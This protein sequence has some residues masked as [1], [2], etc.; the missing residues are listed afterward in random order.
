MTFRYDNRSKVISRL[1]LFGDDLGIF[2]Y[3]VWLENCFPVDK[4]YFCIDFNLIARF[5]DDT[6]NKCL[7]GISRKLEKNNIAGQ[8]IVR[9]VI[10]FVY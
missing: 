8:G 10:K 3:R 9:S 5:S 6:F 4:E 1:G 7:P 2:V